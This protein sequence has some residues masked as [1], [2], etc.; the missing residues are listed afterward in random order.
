MNNKNDRAINFIRFFFLGLAIALLIFLGVLIFGIYRSSIREITDSDLV[1]VDDTEAITQE[2]TEVQT[3]AETELQTDAVSGAEA[4]TAAEVQ[5][6][7]PAET[8]VSPDADA[9]S[10]SAA[11][12]GTAEETASGMDEANLPDTSQDAAPVQSVDG[13]VVIIGE[14]STASEDT[15]DE[16]TGVYSTLNA[17]CNFRSEAGYEDA[18]GN[19]TTIRTCQAGTQVEVLEYSGG[20]TK[21]KIDGTVGYVGAQFVGESETDSE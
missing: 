10:S 16:S 17:A 7:L 12:A 14:E 9:D 19:D 5:T 18:D 11:A 6:E 21:V 1:I 13:D 15:S 2:E 20:W 4:E 3:L 8:E